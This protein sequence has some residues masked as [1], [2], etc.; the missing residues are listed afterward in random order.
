MFFINFIK[1][2]T[3]KKEN[4]KFWENLAERIA[5]VMIWAGF[6]LLSGWIVNM[7]M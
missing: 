4:K 1:T 6:T 3:D 5:I 7:F 2:K